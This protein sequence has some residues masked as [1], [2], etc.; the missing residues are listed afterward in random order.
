MKHL[1]EGTIHAWLDGALSEA[2]ARDVE[3]HVADCASCAAGVAEARGFIAA[4][5]PLPS[6]IPT[7]PVDRLTPRRAPEPSAA[8]TLASREP[9]IA[10]GRQPVITDSSASVRADR[11]LEQTATKELDSMRERVRANVAQASPPSVA[12]TPRM[13][14]AKPATD[15]GFA[16]A[17]DST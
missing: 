1:D 5:S 7:Q 10:G 16:P 15:R 11:A 12:L 3:R 17:R 4:T 6:P 9:V 14:A 13:A 2:E 8:P